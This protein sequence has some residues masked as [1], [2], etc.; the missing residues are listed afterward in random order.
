MKRKTKYQFF[1]GAVA[2][3]LIGLIGLTYFIGFG[4]NNCDQ[5]P[6]MT[7]SCFCCHMFNSRGY[8]S[9]GLFGLLSGM[10]IGGILGALVIQ[11]LWKKF[12]SKANL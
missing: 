3:I 8:E 1:I 12:F 10:F 6:T 11:V 5:L 4:G 9:C 2:A 7:C